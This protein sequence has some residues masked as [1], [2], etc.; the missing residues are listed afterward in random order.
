MEHNASLVV[1][2]L[3]SLSSIG[4]AMGHGGREGRSQD[5]NIISGGLTTDL[6]D[7]PSLS[8][9]PRFNRDDTDAALER[10]RKHYGILEREDLVAAHD[11]TMREIERGEAELFEALSKCHTAKI[12][13]ILIGKSAEYMLRNAE[14]SY[15]I[16]EDSGS[17]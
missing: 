11:A 17:F 2:L 14:E 1:I 6:S 5:A 15:G 10:L 7:P 4:L 8:D 12:R 9:D 3:A 13:D 16:E